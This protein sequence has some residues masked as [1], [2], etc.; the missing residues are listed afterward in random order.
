MGHDEDCHSSNIHEWIEFAHS[1]LMKFPR[2][3]EKLKQRDTEIE[4]EFKSD[5]TKMDDRVKIM[6]EYSE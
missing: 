4:T 3:V 1:Q 2:L 6:F 5:L